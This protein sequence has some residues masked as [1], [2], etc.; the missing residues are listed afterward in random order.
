MLFEGILT[1]YFFSSTEEAP[2]RKAR[3]LASFSQYHRLPVYTQYY[4]SPHIHRATST[5]VTPTPAGSLSHNRYLASCSGFSAVTQ[6][7]TK[8]ERLSVDEVMRAD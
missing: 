2:I 5:I 6:G 4:S 3:R 1:G 7:E 8:V